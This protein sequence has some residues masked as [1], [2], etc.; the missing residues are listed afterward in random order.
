MSPH[1]DRQFDSSA[2]TDKF[3]SSP[4][5]PLDDAAAENAAGALREAEIEAAQEESD[6]PKVD[7]S[8]LEQ[9]SID[10]LRALARELEIPDRGTIIEQDE[11]IVEIR[12]RL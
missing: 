12:K 6:A 7:N 1:Y 10:E 2:D 9:M 11:L 4:G 3:D 5:G 8:R